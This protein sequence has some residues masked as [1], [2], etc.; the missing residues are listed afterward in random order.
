MLF[1][2]LKGFSK[3]QNDEL[4]TK[5]FRF[6]RKDILDQLLNPSNHI[7]Y[8]TWGDAFFIC[9]D[10]PVALAEIA[11][12]IRDKIRNKDWA[13][14]G[15]TEGIAVRIALH[16][17]MARVIMG[18]DGTVSNVV[19]KGVDKTARIEPVTEPND[20]F[21]SDL[22]HQLLVNE[23]AQ[24]IRGVAIGRRALAK[25]F[26]EMDLFRIV[27]TSE[28]LQQPL[29]AAALQTRPMPQ[30]KRKPTDR[31]RTDFLYQSFSAIQSYF[32]AALSQLS[33]LYPD[34]ETSLR[35]IT[36][37]KFVCEIYLHGQLKNSCKV[38]IGGHHFAGNSISYS[39]G[40]FGLD[41]DNS[42]NE[43]LQVEDDGSDIFLKPLMSMDYGHAGGK[44][45]P[46]QA[47]EYLWKRL[48]KALEH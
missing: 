39:E 15:L 48:T 4:K 1:S 3:I 38:W 11:L 14:F 19:G 18:P 29:P 2:D 34:V 9:S 5:L 47:A 37:T 25:S 44:M 23:G 40:R 41:T 33:N 20:V 35:V 45:T 16:A 7:Y 31:E 13:H 30:I 24:N 32:Q 46:E 27:W 17:Q 26:G 8:N 22:F 6:T 21:C 28:A 42:V 43:L 10:N 36:N 12:Q